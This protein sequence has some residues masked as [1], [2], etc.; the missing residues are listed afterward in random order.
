MRVRKA[1]ARHAT[2]TGTSAPI[3]QINTA[4]NGNSEMLVPVLPDRRRCD[5]WVDFMP[6][7]PNV[8][9]FQAGSE[10]PRWAFRPAGR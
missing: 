2:I 9:W 3:M 4:K 6:R 10:R 1:E 8:A 5:R 7:V